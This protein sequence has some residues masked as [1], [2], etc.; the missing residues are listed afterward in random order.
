MI[1]L[2]FINIGHSKLNRWIQLC[3]E[4]QKT[5]IGKVLMDVDECDSHSLYTCY[6]HDFV[7]IV[8][9]CCHKKTEHSDMEHKVKISNSQSVAKLDISADETCKTA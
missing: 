8:H 3:E 7:R 4:V 5:Y 9:N 1:Y 2:P 6:L